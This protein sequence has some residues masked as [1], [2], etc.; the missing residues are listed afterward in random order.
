MGALLSA[1]NSHSNVEFGEVLAKRL[2]DLE[3]EDIGPHVLFVEKGFQKAAGSSV[4]QGGD[5]EGEYLQVKGS[6][7][8]RTMVYSILST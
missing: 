2:I 3:L 7:H 5:L 1:Y 6:V 8:K 4:F